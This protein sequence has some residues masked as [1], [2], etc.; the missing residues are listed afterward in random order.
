MDK[1]FAD[2]RIRINNLKIPQE[3]LDKYGKLEKWEYGFTKEYMRLSWH[4]NRDQASP[5]QIK[6][7]NYL[8][9]RKCKSFTADF[10]GKKQK[11]LIINYGIYKFNFD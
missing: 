5:L 8:K 4:I 2:E 9:S 1:I 6:K 7:F 11:G 10:K 3:Y